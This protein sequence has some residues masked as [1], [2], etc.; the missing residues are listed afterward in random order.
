MNYSVVVRYPTREI[1]VISCDCCP[2]VVTCDVCSLTVPTQFVPTLNNR[3]RLL[4]QYCPF[5]W[6]TSWKETV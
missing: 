1:A 2:I 4:C 6:L 5:A 3:R